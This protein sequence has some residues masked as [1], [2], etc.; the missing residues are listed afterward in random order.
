M[1]VRE[2]L[3]SDPRV[4]AADAPARAAAELLLRPNVKSALVVD[5]DR[6]VGCV[7]VEGIVRAVAAGADLRTL[8]VEAI[9]ERDVTTIAPD[10]PLDQALRLMGERDLERLPVMEDGR[11]VGV[12]PREPL[13][14]RLAED[15]APSEDDESFGYR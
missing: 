2:A 9:C 3:V 13:L 10:A 1:I 4:L 15:E 5:G 14:R 11:L 7:S 8:P 12:L 6:L